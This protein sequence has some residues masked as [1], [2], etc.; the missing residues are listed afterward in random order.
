MRLKW[1]LITVLLCIAAVTVTAQDTSIPDNVDTSNISDDAVNT[2]AQKLYCPVCEN[3]PLDTCGTAACDDWR[4][5]IR[6]MLAT[7]MNEEA[8]IDNFVTRFGDRVVGTPRDPVIAGRRL[9]SI[10]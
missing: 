2:V 3:I 10:L 4:N 1:I 8:I 9:P 5:E 7:G 6:I